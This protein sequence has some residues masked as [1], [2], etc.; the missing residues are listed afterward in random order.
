MFLMSRVIF[1]IFTGSCSL[2]RDV[3][4]SASV[5]LIILL[6]VVVGRGADIAGREK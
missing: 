6:V 3:V 5:G 4:I 1:M 2:C